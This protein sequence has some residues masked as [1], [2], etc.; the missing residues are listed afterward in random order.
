MDSKNKKTINTIGKIGRVVSTIMLVLTILAA[1]AVLACTAGAAFL[2][3]ET[4]DIT[5]DGDINITSAGTLFAKLDKLLDIKQEG[6][7][8]QV[9]LAGTGDVTVSIAGDDDILEDSNLTK[10]DNGYKID[11]NNRKISL[12]TGRLVYCLAVSLLSCICTVAVLI[13]VRSLMKS[14]EVCETP[15]SDEIIK[16]M[17]RFGWSLVPFAFLRGIDKTAL[18]SIASKSVDF[19]IGI[20]FT[21]IAG[22][23]VVFM[24]AVIFTYGAQLQKESD[25]TL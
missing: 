23:L 7:G 16:N 25:E 17:K 1:A 12:N 21:V 9:N 14:L 18:S 11:I 13:M 2:P 5:L 22:I 8:A 24:L 6:D 20:D 3:K 4:I 10:I 15:F 19:S